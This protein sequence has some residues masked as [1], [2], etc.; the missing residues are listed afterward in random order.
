M[1]R[2]PPSSTHSPSATLFGYTTFEPTE[3]FTVNLSNPVNATIATGTGTGTITNDDAQ[4]T[5]SISNGT[6]N[7]GNTGTT[8]IRFSL[9][10]SNATYQTITVS[11]ATADGTAT[12]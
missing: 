1:T 6:A 2:R 11:A 4:P 8:S 7:E 12:A 9:T 3:T 10:L 5:V